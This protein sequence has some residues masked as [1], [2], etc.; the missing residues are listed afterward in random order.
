[1]DRVTVDDVP[2]WSYRGVEALY[3]LP[4]GLFFLYGIGVVIAGLWLQNGDSAV[5]LS[6][7]LYMLILLYIVVGLV[8]WLA[9]PILLFLDARNVSRADIPWQPSGALYAVLGFFFSWLVL[10]HY[11]YKRHQYVIDRGRG[12]SWWVVVPGCFAFVGL[13]WLASAVLGVNEVTSTALSLGSLV[14]AAGVLS[15]ALYF[16][17]LHVRLNSEWRP[18]PA[19]KFG[20]ALFSIILPI[21]PLLYG[22]YYLAKRRSNYGLKSA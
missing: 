21:V 19:T 1:M 8:T 2:S 11:L 9:T 22:G 3:L 4:R 18:N 10:A 15:I 16:D 20:L 17:C 13:V 7:P 5:F 14:V 6:G 12:A